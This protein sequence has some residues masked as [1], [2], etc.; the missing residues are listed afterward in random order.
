MKGVDAMKRL[1]FIVLFVLAL[2]VTAK[3]SGI[4]VD[5]EE[6]GG[7]SGRVAQVFSSSRK[8]LIARSYASAYAWGLANASSGVSA[9]V[10]TASLAASPPPPMAEAVAGV[11]IP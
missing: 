2:S 1:L 5:G 9:H 8:Q 10:S 3:A 11:S 6:V 4:F 7:V